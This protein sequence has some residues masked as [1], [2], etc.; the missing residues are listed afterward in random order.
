[1]IRKAV[2]PS[3]RKSAVLVIVAFMLLGALPGAVSADG[4]TQQGVGIPGPEIEFTV[5]IVV[6]VNV[7]V[8]P[9]GNAT[10]TAQNSAALNQTAQAQ[11]GTASASNGGVAVSGP[12]IAGAIGVI[13]QV[14]VQV[15]ACPFSTTQ[16]TQTALNAAA[17]NQASLARSGNAAASGVGSVAI[18]GPATSIA[19]ATIHQRNVQIYRC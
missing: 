9:F 2:Q 16:I 5:G 10:Q 7:Q 17:L 8:D 1:M 19:V 12:A 4:P 18:S 3:L 11:A 6:P 15:N 13:T 14:N